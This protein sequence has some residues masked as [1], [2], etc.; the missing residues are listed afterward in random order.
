MDKTRFPTEASAAQL[1]GNLAKARAMLAHAD[2]VLI[3]AGAG[4]STAAG[5]AY[6]GARFLRAFAPFIAR[7]GMTDMYS[8]GFYPFPTDEDRWAYW[9]N[10]VN[11]NRYEPPALPLYR[12]LLD[13]A[14]D[15]DCFVITT[16]VDAQFEK[17]GFDREHLF[18]TQG[19]YG[20]NQ[21]K[22]GCHQRVYSN[23][24]VVEDILAATAE[25]DATRAPSELV[26]HCPVCGGPMTV[27][28][29]IDGFF[30]EDEEW[31]AAQK[32]YLDFVEGMRAQPTVLLELGVGWNTPIIIRHPFER[33]AALMDAPLIRVNFDDA[34]I[35]NRA[36]RRGISLQGDIAELWP[37]IS[38][39]PGSAK[40]DEPSKPGSEA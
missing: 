34:H 3:G 9:A 26:P 29:R 27:H 33:L 6:S 19:D 21:C 23:K 14:R 13:Y 36:A 20:F 4:L 35:S 39:A 17:A 24:K 37:R 32:R 5:L 28:L 16:N 11:A 40:P 18:A 22:R 15:R 7:Y 2:R 30:V 31:H 10:H 25:G 1:E 12:D 8:A 38:P